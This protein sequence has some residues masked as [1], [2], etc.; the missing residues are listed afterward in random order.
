[1]KRILIFSSFFLITFISC[2]DDDCVLSDPICEETPPTNEVCLAFFERWFFDSSTS[3][4]EKIGYSGCEDYGF[5]TKEEC[6][7]CECND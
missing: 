3:T 6:E 5:S 4:C 1:M 7:L 2:K